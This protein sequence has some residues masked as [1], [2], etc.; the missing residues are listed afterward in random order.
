[1]STMAQMGGQACTFKGTERK[2]EEEPKSEVTSMMLD[3]PGHV[4]SLG[5][6]LSLPLFWF[7][8][9]FIKS[10]VKMLKYFLVLASVA[11][12][13]PFLNT[14]IQYDCNGKVLHLSKK[15]NTLFII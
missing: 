13:M 12:L 8:M 1:M 14:L 6:I 15:E 11:H 2:W 10:V 4:R 7:N 9:D 3:L 5:F